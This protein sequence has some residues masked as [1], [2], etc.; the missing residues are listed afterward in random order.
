MLDSTKGQHH[1]PFELENR[2]IAPEPWR[3]GI[4]FRLH[5]AKIRQQRPMIVCWMLVGAVMVWLASVAYILVRT[6][7]FSAFSELLISNTTLQQSGPDAVVTQLLVE[8]SLVQSAIEM[9]KSSRVLERAVDRLGLENIELI[10]PKSRSI[11]DIGLLQIFAPEQ[12]RSETSRK[13]TAVAALRSNITV[14]RVGTS[15]IISVRG[16]ARTAE[17]AARLTNEIAVSFVQEQNDTSAVVTTSA[18]LRERIKVLGPTAR[19]ISEA[20][21]PNSKDGPT[22]GVML[23]LAAVLGAALGVSVGLAIVLFDRRVRS[24]EQLTM[25][26]AECFGYLPRMVVRR[27]LRR[28]KRWLGGG[29]FGARMLQKLSPYA[30]TLHYSDP[31]LGSTLRG[32]VLRRARSAVLERRG[33]VPHFVGITSCR[34]AEG[35]TTFAAHWAGLI[36][37]DGSRVLLVDASN[38]AARS[39]S[40]AP[41]ETQGLYQLLR[42][43]A[44]PGDVIRP[45]VRPNLDFLPSG[46]AV[47]NI[48]MQW[49][50]LVQAVTESGDCAYEWVI[51]DLPALTPVADVRSAG[52]IVDELLIVVEWG[53][54]SE[55]QLQQALQSL[56]PVRDKILGVVINK[57]PWASSDPDT[58][59][60]QRPARGAL[61]AKG[62]LWKWFCEIPTIVGFALALAVA[63]AFGD[64]YRLGISD[65]LKIKVQEWPD[66]GGEYTVTTDGLVSLPLVGN[67]NAAGLHVKDLAQEISDRL[68]RRAGGAERPFAAVEIIHFRPFSILGDVQRPGEY[69]YRPGLTI[70]QAVSTAGGYYRPD[71]GLQILRLD[72]DVAL[73]KGDIRTLLLKQNRL[74]MRAARLTASLAG[75]ES[76]PIPPELENEKEDP[77][78]SAIIESERAAFTRDNDTAR[79]EASSLE[80]IRSLYQREIDSL[81]GQIEA[82]KQEK[83][84]IQRQLDELRSLS[85]RGLALSPTLFTLE[86]A[87]AQIVNQQM[88]AET[89]IVRAEENVTSAEQR[90]RERAL[91]RIRTNTRELQLANDEIGEVRARLGTAND[92]LKEAQFSAPAEAR[93]RLAEQGQ[94]PSFTVVRKEG[95]ITREI[96][97]DE[98]TLVEPDDIIK[99]PTVT[100]KPL[101]SSSYINLSRAGRSQEAEP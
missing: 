28:P 18:A 5:L 10:L 47:G 76:V 68:Q 20:V 70:V 64:E 61:A 32:A 37:G 60:A 83:S 24:A 33:D 13:Q 19:I 63:P 90:V 8:N 54:T 3:D 17:D 2:S 27:G 23:A 15:Q 93:Q 66:I 99:V 82:L 73:A 46:D 89:E 85:A 95:E 97:A 101:A 41:N 65:R 50:N 52:Q 78:V 35:K 36:A 44:V 16:R 87:A 100:S 71:L 55:G 31:E 94:R 38:A 91:E 81:R 14:N 98:T 45:Q 21:P 72:R 25:T 9:A 4:G 34:R 75:R 51:L 84:T 58:R 42:G 69:P 92:L 7:A 11:R 48:D 1:F 49:H 57:T 62:R 86:R 26:S 40:L 53:R 39:N 80:N 96:V 67:V 30:F 74:V 88:S 22:A 29:R 6:P 43:A 77:T 59:V 12:E 79:S 56:G